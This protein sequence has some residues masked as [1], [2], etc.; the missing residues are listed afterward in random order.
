MCYKACFYNGGHR[1]EKDTHI[2]IFARAYKDGKKGRGPY[3]N[4]RRKNKKKTEKRKAKL[5]KLAASPH[6]HTC[7]YIIMQQNNMFQNS[8]LFLYC[9][10]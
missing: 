8:T 5:A 6:P 1:K 4:S 3:E 7:A 10:L 2:I 9:D